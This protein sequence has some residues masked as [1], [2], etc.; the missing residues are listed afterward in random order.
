MGFRQASSEGKGGYAK[1][2]AYEDRGKYGVGAV[3]TSKK[4]H[5]EDTYTTDFSSNYVKFIGESHEKAKQ[6]S[7][8]AKNDRNSTEKIIPA[9]IQ[10]TACDV[11]VTYSQEK[12]KWYTEFVIFD[13]DEVEGKSS[14][15]PKQKPKEQPQEVESGSGEDE[16]LPF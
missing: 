1:V 10:I 12:Q 6:F 4:P 13:F 5:G 7:L 8:P 11:T 3:S 15:K 2:W 9:S 16:D 14:A